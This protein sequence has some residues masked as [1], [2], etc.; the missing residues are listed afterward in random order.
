MG[1]DCTGYPPPDPIADNQCSKYASDLYLMPNFC[2]QA[3]PGGSQN[4]ITWCQRMS[5]ANE[6]KPVSTFGV[7]GT[8]CHYD[9]CSS[10]KAV[11][12]D[13]CCN[14][15]CGVTGLGVVCQRQDFTG[16][17]LTCCM[18]DLE[19]NGGI[20]DI[21]LKTNPPACFSDDNKQHT[22]SPCYRSVTSTGDTIYDVTTD[23]NGVVTST[24]TC[25]QAGNNGC[26]DI[27]LNYCTGGDIPPDTDP[28][29]AIQI[30]A[31]RWYDAALN[32]PGPCTNVLERQLFQN[33]PS[34][35]LAVGMLPFS[36][37]CRPKYF[38]NP[39]TVVDGIT[40]G[41]GTP[42]TAL[43]A[44]GVQWAQTMFPQLIAKYNS[45]GFSLGAVPGSIGYNPFQDYLYSLCCQ[46]PVMCQSTLDNTCSIYSARQLSVNP[47]ATNWCGCYLPAT[48]Y[49]KYVDAYQINKE[50]TPTCNR[51]TTIPLVNGGN[52]PIL[53]NQSI[54]VID[55]VTINLNNT[56][57]NGGINISQLCGNC[58]GTFG[59]QSN[60]ECIVQNTTID[61]AQ[62]NLGNIDLLNV[63][64]NTTCTVTNPGYPDLPATLQVPCDQASD[65]N[66]VYAQ[67]QAALL[68]EQA[69]Q[70]KQTIIIY[71]VII[72][73]FLILMVFLYFLIRPALRGPPPDRI[74]YPRAPAAKTAP[75]A[76]PP[77]R[78]L[79]NTYIGT[80]SL[81]TPVGSSLPTGPNGFYNKDIGT[82]MI[83]NN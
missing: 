30:L 2:A 62:S 17:P 3:G 18:K 29:A 21:S 52:A 49:Q 51:T 75:A 8:G 39:T 6:W 54:C 25:A 69:A 55:D 40:T 32:K 13:G 38:A 79:G 37:S 33:L 57:V 56:T 43:S 28:S 35:C 27:L 83:P 60:C 53:C 12:G 42:V 65:P 77:P 76:A 82:K 64:T 15:C 70:N 71:L 5:T 73:V 58:G 1:N 10:Y 7:N 81:S 67:A 36:T 78:P 22:C 23:S 20:D 72:G 61:G 48:E 26:S 31:E 11:P 63:C 45:L 24:T 59:S 34:K 66:S 14:G 74:V 46:V 68:A 50:C 41:A 80:K 47:D 9:T 4:R 44:A 16:D 19:C